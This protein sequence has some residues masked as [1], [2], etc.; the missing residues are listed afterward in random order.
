RSAP[1]YPS[2]LPRAAGTPDLNRMHTRIDTNGE[3]KA[4]SRAAEAPACARRRFL[5]LHNPLAGRNRVSLVRD[6]VHRLELAGA[7][8]DFSSR[9]ASDAE[10]NIATEIDAYDAVI[11]S[12]GDGTARN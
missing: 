11:A 2:P 3:P 9:S 7:I 4:T 1:G 12:G 6:V 8:V 5:I 10:L